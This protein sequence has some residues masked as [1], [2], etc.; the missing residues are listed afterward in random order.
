MWLSGCGDN[1]KSFDPCEKPFI[2]TGKKF[3][4]FEYTYR[5]SYQCRKHDHSFEDSNF[6]KY[7]VGDTL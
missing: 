5:Y 4:I 1:K 7:S 6:N 2:I 3:V